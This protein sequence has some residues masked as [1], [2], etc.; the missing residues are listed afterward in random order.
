[1]ANVLPSGAR[2]SLCRRTNKLA[3]CEIERI[4]VDNDGLSREISVG[5]ERYLHRNAALQLCRG[6]RATGP[7]LRPLGAFF[8]STAA[9]EHPEQPDTG[10]AEP[11]RQ[12]IASASPGQ[13]LGERLGH[14]RRPCATAVVAQV[15]PA[16][17]DCDSAA[18]RR[19]AQIV[20]SKLRPQ[21]KYRLP[22]AA[23]VDRDLVAPEQNR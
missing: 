2:R 23:P 7:N 21:P 19:E 18:W 22:G 10:A 5:R 20:H 4:D 12:P 13:S 17:D 9:N 16:T 8:R 1:M 3:E 15:Q 14:K 6:A 11:F